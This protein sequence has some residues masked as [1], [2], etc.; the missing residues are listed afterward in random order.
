MLIY[1]MYEHS[2]RVCI[3]IYTVYFIIFKLS[4][5]IYDLCSNDTL[6]C[7]CCSSSNVKVN[8]DSLVL[9]LNYVQLQLKIEKKANCLNWLVT[10]SIFTLTQRTPCVGVG[11]NE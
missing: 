10:V 9:Y 8:T 11:V 4:L 5:W 2:I 1:C 6:L 7:Y 3:Y